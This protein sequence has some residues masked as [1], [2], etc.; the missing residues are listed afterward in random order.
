MSM[1][2]ADTR[3]LETIIQRHGAEP[4]ELLQVLREVQD[5][6][7]HVSRPAMRIVADGLGVPLTQV[8]AVT[9]FYSFL[10]TEPVGRFD[11]RLSD[12]ITDHML[13][14]RELASYACQRWGVRLGETRA[15][16]ALSFS[17]T[18]CTGM[19]DQGPAAL[20]NGLAL[21][22]LDPARVDRIADLVGRGAPLSD[23]PAEWFA[24]AD[25]IERRSLLLDGQLEPGSA[26]RVVGQ[27]GREA[28]LKEIDESGLR[29]RGGAGFKTAAKWQYCFEGPEGT[30]PGD[31]AIERYVV[32]NADEGEPGT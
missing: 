23:W 12:S 6:F 13:G 28:I 29:G 18:S 17:L 7:R 3:V 10:T 4:T 1:N 27:H 21:T 19:C 25:N 16:G 14:S 30:T 11:I 5:D 8:Q 24:V 15:D 9:E 26:L 22:H 32:C 2:P 20:V 31:P